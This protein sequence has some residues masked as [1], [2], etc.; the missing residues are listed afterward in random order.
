M[1]IISG[2]SFLVFCVTWVMWGAPMTAQELASDARPWQLVKYAVQT[3]GSHEDDVDRRAFQKRLTG[4]AATIG[5]EN[6]QGLWKGYADVF[7]DTMATIPPRILL[8][9]G[10]PKNNIPARRDTLERTT[11]AITTYSNGRYDNYYFFCEKDPY[12]RIESWR[13]FPTAEQRAEIADSVTNTDVN[14][15][16]IF[17]ESIRLTRLLLSDKDQTVLFEEVRDDL[18]AI[19]KQLTR[20]EIWNKFDLSH[21]AFDSI[22]EFDALDDHLSPLDKLFFRLN[23]SALQRL[24]K[25]GIFH[26]TRTSSNPQTVLVEIGRWNDHSVGFAY[27]PKPSDLPVVSSDNFFALKHL[28]NN[29][30]LFKRTGNDEYEP[31]PPLPGSPNRKSGKVLLLVPKEKKP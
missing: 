4:E 12:W 1:H 27:A 14:A 20:S 13:Q 28:D 6:M 25:A 18:D 21:I 31:P 7:I 24:R 10:V 22:N 29:W 11:V 5:A 9:P 26:I 30:W 17:P 2:R 3:I 19:A 15:S 23:L 16:E 8:V